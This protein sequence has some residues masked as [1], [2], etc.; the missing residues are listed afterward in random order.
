MNYLL[1]GGLS[2]PFDRVIDLFCDFVEYRVV[3]AGVLSL[4]G[5]VMKLLRQ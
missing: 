4:A 3:V 5:M 2:N 1:A